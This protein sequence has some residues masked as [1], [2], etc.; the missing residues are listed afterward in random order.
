MVTRDQARAERPGFSSPRVGHAAVGGNGQHPS[1]ARPECTNHYQ[2]GWPGP[3]TGAVPE[4]GRGY[5]ACDEQ[6]PGKLPVIDG[7]RYGAGAAVGDPCVWVK[8]MA[9]PTGMPARRLPG[10][11]LLLLAYGM[12]SS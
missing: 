2:P 3:G 4:L 7:A 8:V 1:G 5:A 6:C 11:C 12:R 10:A 9:S